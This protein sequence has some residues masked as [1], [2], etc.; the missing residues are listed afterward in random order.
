MIVKVPPG[1]RDKK[2]SFKKLADY[3]S[4]GLD[5]SEESSLKTSWDY[6]TQY[7]TREDA[8]GDLNDGNANGEK[9]IAVEIGNLESLK[10]APHEM[11]AVASRNLRQKNPVYHYILSWPE[12]EWPNSQAIFGAARHTLKALGMQDHQYIVAIHSDTDNLHAH[13]EVNRIHPKTYKAARLEWAH[14]TLEPVLKK[15]V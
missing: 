7:I 13:I 11:R 2:S 3:L 1:R 8:V 14:A 10:T 9:T 5:Q 6:L 4:Q 15:V 12:K